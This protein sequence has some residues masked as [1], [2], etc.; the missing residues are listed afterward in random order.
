MSQTW[1]D[2]TFEAGHVAQT[3]LQNMEN[4]FASLKSSFS[5]A[6]QP[7]NPVVGMV[8]HDTA[9]NLKKQYYG[10]AWVT[11]YDF[12]NGYVSNALNCERNVI[13]G[14]GLDGGGVLSANRTINHTAHTGDVIG[15]DALTI[16]SLPDNIV[17]P[18]GSYPGTLQVASFGYGKD[19]TEVPETSYTDYSYFLL[20]CPSGPTVLRIYAYM[21]A[22][23]VY[24]AQDV[25]L[26]LSVSGIANSA[27]GVSAGTAYA[28]K[29]CGSVSMAGATPGTVYLCT[30]QAYSNSA[31]YPGA[32]KAVSIWWE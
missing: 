3:D 7:A 28:V 31:L 25:Y 8:W 27:G 14:T 6:V 2:N 15:A 1:N 4:N 24:P 20:K 16:A 9:N 18:A 10:A 22:D 29:D 30:V 21:R 32:I 13:A 23:N 19:G 11:I 12:A 5:G 17:K 26:R